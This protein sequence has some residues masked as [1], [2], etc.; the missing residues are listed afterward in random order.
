MSSCISMSNAH[1][2]NI[3]FEVPECHAPPPLPPSGNYAKIQS[4]CTRHKA[5]GIE[6]ISQLESYWGHARAIT[7]SR[8]CVAAK[9][10]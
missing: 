10:C 1:S 4:E 9:R 2:K 3:S 8:S 6:L 5:R 7:I